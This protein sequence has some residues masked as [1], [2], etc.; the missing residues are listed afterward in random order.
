MNFMGC[1]VN[2]TPFQTDEECGNC[3]NDAVKQVP[4]VEL[5][6]P[7][8]EYVTDALTQPPTQPAV[9]REDL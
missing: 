9:E 7:E 3:L 2:V 5:P 1:Y 6:E 8:S 4:K